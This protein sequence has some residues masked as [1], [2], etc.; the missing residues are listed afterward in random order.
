MEKSKV[1]G[2]GCCRSACGVSKV[3]SSLGSRIR[4][5]AALMENAS[6]IRFIPEKGAMRKLE[7]THTRRGQ[8]VIGPIF[9]VRH[10][11]ISS[12][13]VSLARRS[14]NAPSGIRIAQIRK[15]KKK[16]KTK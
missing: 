14:I 12:R 11:F 10:D 3:S 13:Y 16:K 5:V 1:G 15:K 8:A 4:K 2:C 7:N 6:I 9:F